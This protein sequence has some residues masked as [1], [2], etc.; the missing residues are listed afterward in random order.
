MNGKLSSASH[1]SLV[2]RRTSRSKELCYMYTEISE[3]GICHVDVQ[4][5]N[6]L[7]A[8]DQSP[9]PPLKS[10]ISRLWRKPYQFRVIDFDQSTGTNLKK[11]LLAKG[12]RGAISFLLEDVTFHAM[13]S[14]AFDNEDYDPEDCGDYL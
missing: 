4:Y 9:S 7:L 8:P 10:R 12:Q 1:I 13:Q 3:M 11:Q 5:G 2:D 6:I 14:D